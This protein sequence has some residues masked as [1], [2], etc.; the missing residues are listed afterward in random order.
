[1]S[2]RIHLAP[3][4]LASDGT[5][6]VNVAMFDVARRPE[7]LLR[8]ALREPGRVFVG[9]EMTRS[10]VERLLEHAQHGVAEGT[11]RQVGSRQK[12]TRA[13]RR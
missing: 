7:L 3:V 5:V 6:I 2:R 13:K 1:M 8:L 11:A 10:E 12:Q 4:A 9:V